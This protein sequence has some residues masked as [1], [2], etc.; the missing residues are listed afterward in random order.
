VSGFDVL[1]VLEECSRER[2][3]IEVKGTRQSIRE[4]F[5]SV[6]RNEWDTAVNSKNYVFHLWL[7]HDLPVCLCVPAKIMAEHMP[8]DNNGGKWQAVTVPFKTFRDY[9]V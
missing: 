7:L 4:A 5:I 3:Q 8:A 6:T 9:R 1:S 2:L